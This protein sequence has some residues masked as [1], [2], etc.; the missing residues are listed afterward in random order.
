MIAWAVEH[1]AL[2]HNRYQLGEDGRSLHRRR[3]G[4][5][6]VL[7]CAPFGRVVLV[8]PPGAAAASR[9]AARW[10]RGIYLGVSPQTQEHRVY[11]ADALVKSRSVRRVSDSTA[12]E[13]ALLHA[14]VDGGPWSAS[15]GGGPGLLL[16]ACLRSTPPHRILRAAR[17]GVTTSGVRIWMNMVSLMVA[18]V[19]WPSPLAG[20]VPTPR[21]VGCGSALTWAARDPVDGF[22]LRP[23]RP[24]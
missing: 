13:A 12:A 23:P 17:P 19:A 15:A 10:S 2:S 9:L 14:A 3:F 20:A 5:D 11:V 1:A 24:V 21:P 7:A 16:T 6:V 4:R 8:A 18:R 22:A